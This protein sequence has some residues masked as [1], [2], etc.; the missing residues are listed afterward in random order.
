MR[1][2]DVQIRP[3]KRVEY[4]LLV[5][6]GFFGSGERVEL[7]DG[8]L[9]VS[10]PQS[11]SHFTAI[12]LVALAL[13]RAFGD[14]WEVRA[15]GP[16]ALDD[17]SEPE[18]DVAVVRGGP[19]DYAAAHPAEP[20]LVVEVSLTRF[21]FDR[22]YKSSLY[23]RAG[24]PE[25]WIVNLIDRELEVRRRPARSPAAP[26]GWDYTSVDVLSAQDSVSP[27]ASPAAV[28]VVADLLP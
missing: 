5:Q 23:A 26:Y 21:A 7:I 4:E 28:I 6:K 11:A 16:I 25:Y 13:T 12:R 2:P 1:E 27:L 3:L 20:V 9:M 24:R 10:E 19:R 18:P 14:G 17:T 22:K 15:Q 8:L